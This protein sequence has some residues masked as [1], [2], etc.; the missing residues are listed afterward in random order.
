MTMNLK[1]Y[2]TEAM[3][4]AIYPRPTKPALYPFLGLA[5]EAGEV[6]GK[7]LRVTN[8][9]S[10]VERKEIAEEL[11]DCCWYAAVCLNELGREM[12]GFTDDPD[13]VYDCSGVGNFLSLAED[14]GKVLGILK[15]AMRDDHWDFGMEMPAHVNAMIY[16]AIGHVIASIL[17]CCITVGYKM[18]DVLDMNIAKLKSRQARGVLGGSG[19]DR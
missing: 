15:K 17:G 11:G 6:C 1:T 3:K 19:D 2:Q 14:S 10:Q 13:G 9:L 5:N 8:K 7:W 12:N 4:T 18:E 16:R